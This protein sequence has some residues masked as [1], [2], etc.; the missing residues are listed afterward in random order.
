MSTARTRWT[1]E[2]QVDFVRMASEGYSA[3]SIAKV[4]GTT[5]GAVIAQRY[6]M[7]A[8]GIEVPALA[9]APKRPVVI[10]KPEKPKQWMITLPQ[11]PGLFR[12]AIVRL[13]GLRWRY[14][15]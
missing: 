10:P 8:Q 4:F 13:A 9:T 14:G 11:K 3:A 5:E 1:P 7:V 6:K 12:R 2:R 15:E